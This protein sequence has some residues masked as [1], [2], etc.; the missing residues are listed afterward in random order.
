MAFLAS[1][2]LGI[3]ASIFSDKFDDTIRDSGQARS[4]L[5]TEVVGNLPMVRAW[6][7]RSIQAIP[8]GADRDTANAGKTTRSAACSV[9]GFEEAVRALRASVLL[10]NSDRP[11]KSVMVTSVAPSEGKTTVAVHFAIAHAQQK[12]KT[13]LIDCDLRRPEVHSKLG[14]TPKTG[15]SAALLNG[16]AWREI[17]VQFENAPG[18][19]LLPAGPSLRG[20]AALIG[21]G[22]QKIL[23]EAE[24]EY[25]LI[26]VDSPP[27]LGF[28]ES[29]HMAAAV[30]GVMIVAVAG[31]T[32]RKALDAGLTTLRRLRAN[33][34]GL[35]LNEVTSSTS[36]G[37][38]YHGYYRQYYKHSSH[39]ETPG[40]A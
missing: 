30:D 1:L 7:G 34:L 26:I 32:S 35:V 10:G 23:A 14:V 6:K 20:C 25:D 17:L 2:C 18:L 40:R 4:L 15:L 24:S 21:A 31:E 16:L 19:T 33:V 27:V 9:A 5:K 8:S 3:T 37:Y 38:S 11:L 36:D 13:L 22:L 39:K 29:L 12:Y 28:S